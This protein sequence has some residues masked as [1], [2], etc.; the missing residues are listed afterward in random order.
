M[1]STASPTSTL[2]WSTLY[3]VS[4]ELPEYLQDARSPQSRALQWLQGDFELNQWPT[5]QV[6]QRYALAVIYYALKG[7]EW[8]YSYSDGDWLVH[9]DECN[10][11]VWEQVYCNLELRIVR[12]LHL[13]NF[14]LDG[15]LPTELG[16]LSHLVE[17]R[18]NGGAKAIDRNTGQYDRNRT[19]LF[20]S[21][22]PTEVGRLTEL[23][24]LNLQ[25]TRCMGTGPFPPN[26]VI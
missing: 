12:T 5:H 15:T 9:Q 19:G 22:L 21:T 17:L 7:E 11:G 20:Q 4:P 26:W 14:V 18:I 8:D 1:R 24:T 16:L 10:L 2:L 13:A 25:N 3:S 23:K 6:I